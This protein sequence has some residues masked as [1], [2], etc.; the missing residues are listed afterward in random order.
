MIISKLIKPEDVRTFENSELSKEAVKL[1]GTVASSVMDT[2]STLQYINIRD[3]L[4][5]HIVV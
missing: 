2:I 1:L 4:L 3:Y 5:A